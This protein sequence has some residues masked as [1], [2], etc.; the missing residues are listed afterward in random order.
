MSIFVRSIA[1][2]AMIIGISLDEQHE[3]FLKCMT[4]S[5]CGEK[6]VKTAF[7]STDTSTDGSTSIGPILIGQ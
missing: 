2:K 5:K 3:V 4:I 7:F 6:I 1:S